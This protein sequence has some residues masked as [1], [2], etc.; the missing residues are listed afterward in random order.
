MI[1]LTSAD[2]VAME[3]AWNATGSQKAK[4]RRERIYRAELEMT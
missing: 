4:L 2:F 1:E 3:A